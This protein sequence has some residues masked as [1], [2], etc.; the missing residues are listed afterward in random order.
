MLWPVRTGGKR[1]K[2]KRKGM[3]DGRST[4]Q[5]ILGPDAVNYNSPV[6]DADSCWRERASIHKSQ[7]PK[8]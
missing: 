7:L 1:K 4:Q 6:L 8:K 3:G 2:K 5:R